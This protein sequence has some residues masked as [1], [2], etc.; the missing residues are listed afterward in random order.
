MNGF[1]MISLLITLVVLCVCFAAVTVALKW[2]RPG[3]ALSRSLPAV[4][5]ALLVIA[6]AAM[7]MISN[8]PS[9]YEKKEDAKTEI[10][11]NMIWLA[12][13]D[14]AFALSQAKKLWERH[15]EPDAKVVLALSYLKN[16]QRDKAGYLLKELEHSSNSPRYVKDKDLKKL[17]DGI[18]GS[19][20][21]DE[22]FRKTIASFTET[23]ERRD[24]VSAKETAVL[25][26]LDIDR[27]DWIASTSGGSS[28]EMGQLTA[29]YEET[30]AEDSDRKQYGE[31]LAKLAV[32]LGRNDQA[33]SLLIEQVKDDPQNEEACSLL[34]D[35]YLS[36]MQPSAAA[37]Q[38]PQY[39]EAMKLAER[40]Q[41]RKLQQWLDEAE[42]SSGLNDIIY[43]RIEQIPNELEIGKELA[44]TV[45]K[46]FAD[47][48]DPQ[49]DFLLS[50]Y[51]YSKQDVIKSADYIREMMK[52]T[53]DMSLPQQYYVQS[54]QSLPEDS[55]QMSID[56]MQERNRWTSDAYTSFT[57]LEGKRLNPQELTGDEMQFAV[58]MS[59]ELIQLKKQ[60]LRISS[61]QASEDGSVDLYVRTENMDT[62]HRSS[63]RLFNDGDAISSFKIEKLSE[64]KSYRRSIMLIIDKSGSMEGEKIETAKLAAQNFVRR[65]SGKEDVGVIAFSDG[66]Q[67]LASV[68]GDKAAAADS[69]GGLTAGGGTNIAPAFE[70]AIRTLG[71]ISGERVAFMMS[72]G[73]DSNFS[74]P[75]TRQEIIRLAGEAGVTIFAVGFDAGYETLRDVAEGT[76]GKYI[77]ATDLEDLM[78]SFADISETLESAYKISYKVNGLEPGT[79]TA[80]LT[81]PKETSA[82][83]SFTI[84][85][86]AAGTSVDTGTG[87]G[88]AVPV[89]QGKTAGFYINAASP[90]RI[91]ASPQGTTKVTFTGAGFKEVKSVTVDRQSVSFHVESD[92]ELTL[93]LAN[94]KPIGAHVVSMRNKKQ[95]EATY[96]LSYAKSSDQES[97]SFGYSTVYGDFISTKNGTITFV[98]NTSVDHFLYDFGGEMTLERE[99]DLKFKGL[100][101]D[102]G[103]TKLKVLP[104]EITMSRDDLGETFDVEAY[105]SLNAFAEATSLDK[106]GLELNLMPKL[107][108]TAE[109]AKDEGKLTAKAGIGGFS[110]ITAL[111]KPVIER[112]L[113]Q[114][115]FLRLN[116]TSVEVSYERGNMG[117]SGETEFEISA[118]SMLKAESIKA[119]IEYEFGK[120]RLVL[121]GEA[122]GLELFK[123]RLGQ[124]AIGAVGGELG[125]EN[126]LW[127]KRYGVLVSSGDKGIP[128]GTTGL[129]VNMGNI[130]VDWTSAA[131]GKAAIGIGTIAD[132]PAR[133]V[134]DMVN[135][136]PFIDIDADS[137]CVLCME[138]STEIKNVGSE[139]WSYE[140]KVEAKALGFKVA[141]T[142]TTISKYRISLGL[143]LE[144]LGFDGTGTVTWKDMDFADQTSIRLD[145]KIDKLKLSGSL[146]VVLVPARFDYSY[147][148]MTGKIAK[149]EKTLRFGSELDV[150]R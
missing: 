125:W 109:Y 86:P 117:I 110:S 139:N 69:I 80:R 23:A 40:E 77:A 67:S 94:N 112:V 146:K 57:S 17:A 66:N 142:S 132:G 4:A 78:K 27:A 15:S 88:T 93:E 25:S 29:L 3:H 122:G 16:G 5:I 75:A 81:G 70:E 53:T 42:N 63:L 130:V 126:S 49:L 72:D 76:G 52:H 129:E 115:K 83:K 121:K 100:K 47:E 34:G 106:F 128:L 45:I 37:E 60:V 82:S 71:G 105:G 51:Y 36:G 55:S 12:N 65:L 32:Y 30:M 79:H 26:Q 28:E 104:S 147:V 99:Q 38:L 144:G 68:S 58:H 127:P 140:G 73:E 97:R 91:I 141:E 59:R 22:E 101:V 102:I 107:E 111:N 135:K 46:P 56:E 21:G 92:T 50:K 33:E 95:E 41:R 43:Q 11:K 62:L 114:I 85:M 116:D 19:P 13:E 137:V 136:V 103:R 96:Q 48:R 133:K 98:G 39:R 14:P 64:A 24:H 113:N 7:E 35:L 9:A 148:E 134:I 118:T 54:L 145:G 131:E 8:R 143:A 87:T 10:V 44:Y 150:I 6:M 149:W 2:Y 84:G 123:Q 18:K 119:G 89:I 138:G 20:L 120:N 61:V 90:G 124:Q 74:N 1:W 108:Y 31:P